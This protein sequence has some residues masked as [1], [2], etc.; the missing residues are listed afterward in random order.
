MS[1]QKLIANDLTELL[2]FILQL[3]EVNDAEIKEMT[4]ELKE[5]GEK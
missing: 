5:Y 1:R 3:Y 2:T 4:K